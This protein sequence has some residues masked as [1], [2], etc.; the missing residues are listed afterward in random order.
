MSCVQNEILVFIPVEKD[1]FMFLINSYQCYGVHALHS[2]YLWL[3]YRRRPEHHH[4]VFIGCTVGGRPRNRWTSSFKSATQTQHSISNWM[5][6]FHVYIAVIF[7]NFKF[8][9]LSQL[10]THLLVLHRYK[11]MLLLAFWWQTIMLI[12]QNHGIFTSAKTKLS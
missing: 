2:D 7:Q 9:L 12:S 4:S 5:T 6:M 3:I 1:L 11:L 10:K 8:S